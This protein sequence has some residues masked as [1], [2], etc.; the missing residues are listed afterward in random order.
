MRHTLKQWILVTRPWSFPAATMPVLVAFSF[1]F[2][3]YK[4]NII[5]DINCIDA[6]LAFLGAMFFQAAGNLISDYY[7]FINNVDRKESF[8][9]N[10]MVIDG[11]FEAKTVLKYGLILL[12]VGCII[13]I[14]LCF[15]SGIYLLFIGL[16]GVVGTLFYYKLKY[17][18]LGDFLI[19]LIFGLMIGLGSY[20]VITR[21]LSYEILF[22][23]VPLGLLI[24]AILHANNTRDMI[25]DKQIGIKTSAILLGIKGAKIKYALLLILSYVIVIILIMMKIVPYS[26]LSVLLTLP[27]AIRNII[28]MSKFSDKSPEII[29]SLDSKTAQL[30]LAFAILFSISNFVF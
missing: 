5:S 28:Q 11:I 18:A 26:C 25:H 9:S 10:R 3:Q 1:A 27:L 14:Y 13:G 6:I 17:R 8:G 22:V 4:N 7:D 19:F 15:Q 23:S 16:A 29:M 24:T 20:Y 12:L 30:V 21:I 2:H